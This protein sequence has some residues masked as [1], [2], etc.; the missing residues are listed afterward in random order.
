MTCY[1]KKQ[2]SDSTLQKVKNYILKG[3]PKKTDENIKP[4]VS[5]KDTLSIEYGII[6]T[7]DRIVIPKN[8][9][10]SVLELIHKNHM[11]IVK[12][13]QVAGLKCGKILNKK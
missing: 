7:G 3:W 11:G 10:P 9:I 8:L 4:I 12:S 2:N 1:K 13:K 5:L 6:T